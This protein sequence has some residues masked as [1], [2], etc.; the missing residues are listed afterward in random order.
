MDNIFEEMKQVFQNFRWI[1]DIPEDQVRRDKICM[2]AKAALLIEANCTSERFPAFIRLAEQAPGEKCYLLPDVVS[3]RDYAS[4][5]NSNIMATVT[6]EAFEVGKVNQQGKYW[7]IATALNQNAFTWAGPRHSV[8]LDYLLPENDSVRDFSNEI[9]KAFYQKYPTLYSICKGLTPYSTPEQICRYWGAAS[10]PWSK[11]KPRNM[12]PDYIWGSSNLS[13]SEKMENWTDARLEQCAFR[14]LIPCQHAEQPDFKLPNRYYE[15]WYCHVFPFRNQYGETI[16]NVIKVYDPESQCKILLP[17]TTWLRNNSTQSQ[18]FCVPYPE[19]KT[20]LYNLD[21]LLKPECRTV[22]LCDSIELADANQR[23]IDTREIVFTSFICSPGKYDQVDWTPLQDKEL[24]VLVS[25][26]SGISLESAALKTQELMGF[27]SENT[28]LQ[29][30]RLL[31]MPVEYETRRMRGFEHIDDILKMY[32][33]Y[34]PQSDPDEFLILTSENEIEEFFLKAEEKINKRPEKW[35]LNPEIPQE[36]KRVA[37]KVNN[38]PQPID[39]IM[40]PLLIRGEATLMYAKKSVGKSSLAYSIAARVA[41]SGF[42]SSPVPLLKGKW[43]SVPAREHKVFYL[44]FENMGAMKSKQEMFQS[45]YIPA[46]NSDKCTANLIM[47]D[48]SEYSIDFSLP[49]NHQKI[50]DMIENAKNNRGTPGKAVD[51]LVID[52]YTGLIRTE[53]PATPA[54]FKELI[55]KIRKMGIAILITHHANSE[56]E[57]R[58]LQSKLDKVALTIKLSRNEEEEDGNLDEQPCIIEY[59]YPRYPMCAKL[60]KPFEIIFDSKKKQWKLKDANHDENA[61]L[62]LISQDFKGL[63]FDRDAICQMVGL[64]KTAL[65]AR[66]KPFKE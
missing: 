55:D 56:N 9:T 25:N 26:H 59:E 54:N 8:K 13:Q 22:I 47:E 37:E 16:M 3:I 61:E 7:N 24:F 19:D 4:C 36:E 48:V 64:K 41:A 39:F 11:I 63:K 15:N 23:A 38:K 50:L 45:G 62:F 31:V 46:K 20:P 66:L 2:E 44:D 43:W 65:S 53:T 49:E 28:D 58:G 27:L 6:C 35:W 18:I 33:N 30:E 14:S 52:T 12:F 10:T 5:Y 32:G 21:L 34:P 60:R 51:L 57:L 42:S 40:R 1:D 29:A 17:L